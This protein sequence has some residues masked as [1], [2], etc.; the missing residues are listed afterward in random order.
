MIFLSVEMLITLLFLARFHA[1]T[2]K[3][4]PLFMEKNHFFYP[5]S[6]SMEADEAL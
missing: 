1:V 4:R 5:K 6:T 2:Y 3:E